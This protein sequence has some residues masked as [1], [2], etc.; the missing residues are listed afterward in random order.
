MLVSELIWVKILFQSC[1]GYNIWH[2]NFYDFPHLGSSQRKEIH[3]PGSCG[4]HWAFSWSLA[5]PGTHAHA[6]EKRKMNRAATEIISPVHPKRGMP[7]GIC[8]FRTPIPACTCRTPQRPKD[9][10]TKFIQHW[11]LFLPTYSFIS[12][13]NNYYLSTSYVP[14]TRIPAVN[15]TEPLLSLRLHFRHHVLVRKHLPLQPDSL[16]SNLSS[17]TN[18]LLNL[19][20]SLDFLV[21]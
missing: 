6:R 1:M 4:L 8:L 16:G 10:R 12:S 11:A 9:S 13:F 14:G 17:A 15:K 19:G 20:K 18:S 2:H 21:C 3:F 7:S 5:A